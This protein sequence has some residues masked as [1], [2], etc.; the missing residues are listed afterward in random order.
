MRVWAVTGTVANLRNPAMQPYRV[1]W[2]L[3]EVRRRGT[4]R[5]KA[6]IGLSSMKAKGLPQHPAKGRGSLLYRIMHVCTGQT[7]RLVRA[8]VCWIIYMLA[9]AFM[10]PLAE[11]KGKSWRTDVQDISKLLHFCS[12][13]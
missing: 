6:S 11:F 9:M 5:R 1:G 3:E 8:E 2:K 10:E 4:G 7:G 13:W 12:F